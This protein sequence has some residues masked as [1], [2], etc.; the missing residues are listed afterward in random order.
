MWHWA[1]GGHTPRQWKHTQLLLLSPPM[2]SG[3]PPAETSGLPPAEGADSPPSRQPP[4]PMVVVGLGLALPCAYTPLLSAACPCVGMGRGG[5]G[6]A[7]V[8]AAAPL[9]PPALAP[10]PRPYTKGA[11]GGRA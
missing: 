7:A 6:G 1:R 2:T 8:L 10:P 5:K 9:L 11:V 3:L 4:L